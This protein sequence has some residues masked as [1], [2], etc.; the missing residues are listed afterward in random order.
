MS[1]REFAPDA[2]GQREQLRAE[3]GARG[4]AALPAAAEWCIVAHR[5]EAAGFQ[6]GAAD[7]WREALEVEPRLPGA[8]LG[9]ARALLALGDA[10][11]AAKESRAALDLHP[12]A[13]DA[14]VEPLL[15]DP[16]EDPWYTLG[17]AEHLAGRLDEAA[18]AYAKSAEKYPWFP[19]PLL[20]TARVELARGR[21]DAAADAARKALK[22]ARFRPDFAREVQA[23]LSQAQGPP[24]P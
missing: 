2:R 6:K 8:H 5:L 20:E 1:L 18:A 10:A 24:Q 4:E 22:R 19:E 11:G 13:A 15:D 21:R 17:Q 12:L 3:R 9:L 14:G 7:A 16:D 23:I